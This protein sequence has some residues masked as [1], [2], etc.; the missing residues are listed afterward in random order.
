MKNINYL[1]LIFLIFSSSCVSKKKLQMTIDA[2]EQAERT[3]QSRINS[4]ATT[5][6][7]GQEILDDLKKEKSAFQEVMDKGKSSFFVD[8]EL[9]KRIKV[10]FAKLNDLQKVYNISTFTTFST[11]KFYLTGEYEIPNE[12]RNNI[13]KD[14]DPLLNEIIKTFD[15][16]KGKVIRVVIAIS[17]YSDGQ[18]ISKNSALYSKLISEISN[19]NPTSDELNLRLSELRA[20]SLSKLIEQAVKEKNVN[21]KQDVKID[22]DIRFYGRGVENPT[23]VTQAQKDDPRRRVVRITWD[24]NPFVNN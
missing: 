21:T 12:Y 10:S 7:V 15:A 16:Q 3:T 18:G 8:R 13:L 4:G 17:G 23:D 9:N 22:Y 5:K 11:S 14:L 24:V 1:I 20:E 2:F 19:K 6:E